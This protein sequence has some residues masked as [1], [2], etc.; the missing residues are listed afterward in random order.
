[1]KVVTIFFILLCISN[2]IL[3]TSVQA[4]QHSLHPE[5]ICICNRKNAE[6][7]EL[8][9]DPT[10]MTIA[11]I[12]DILRHIAP[13][14]PTENHWK[15]ES[16]NYPNLKLLKI[17]RTHPKTGETTLATYTLEIPADG[18]SHT[19]S[20]IW[21][22]FPFR[23]TST[24]IGL[25]PHTATQISKILSE[26]NTR[27]SSV[28]MPIIHCI[29]SGQFTYYVPANPT[30]LANAPADDNQ[31]TVQRQPTKHDYQKEL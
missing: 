4:A 25:T 21:G 6:G 24:D 20:S 8:P 12:T 3:I 10:F 23:T 30:S 17:Q 27:T 13:E 5:L 29:T 2:S 7:L 26:H 31:Y 19:D 22:F 18:K 16:K 14:R 11:N 1:M 9:P 15:F 28:L